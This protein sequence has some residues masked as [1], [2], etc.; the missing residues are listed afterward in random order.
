MGSGESIAP[1]RGAV[2]VGPAGFS[3]PVDRKQ[4]AQRTGP[5]Q[6]C[7]HQALRILTPG[8]LIL[9]SGGQTGVDRAA[10]DCA[11]A[12]QIPYVGWCPR[13]GW[14]EDFPIPPGVLAAYP[15]LVETPASAPEQRTAWNVRDSDATLIVVAGAGLDTSAGTRL[16]AVCAELIFQKPCCVADATVPDDSRRKAGRW[17]AE[18]VESMKRHDRA[19]LVLNVAGPRE[20]QSPGVYHAARRFIDELLDDSHVAHTRSG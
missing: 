2:K 12:R 20:S 16:T 15:L 17:L 6:A 8:Q 1:A 14:A 11:I 9:R 5:H 7:D 19:A 3:S 10:L 18:V 4:A 13:G